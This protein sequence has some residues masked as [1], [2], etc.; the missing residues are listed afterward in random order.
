MSAHRFWWRYQ[1]AS[2]S[3]K[4]TSWPLFATWSPPR[5]GCWPVRESPCLPSWHGPRSPGGGG[6]LCDRGQRKHRNGD[7]DA[8]GHD[9]VRRAQD[10]DSPRGSLHCRL[11]L[12][13]EIHFRPQG[14]LIIGFAMQFAGFDRDLP[15]E[16][17]Q[18]PEVGKALLLGV[19]Y[20]PTAMG[21]LAMFILTRYRLT[22]AES[23]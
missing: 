4:P 19:S 20:I 15:D 13:G 7:V 10:R 14:P 6:R 1:S 17:L 8:D 21:L 18:S 16:A 22:K 3:A 12:C 9:R 23:A 2:A 5:A 11:Q